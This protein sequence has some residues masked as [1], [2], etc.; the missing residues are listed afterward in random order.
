MVLV[1][2][3]S[4]GMWRRNGYALANQI[5]FYQQPRCRE[6]ML[7]KDIVMMQACAAVMPADSFLIALLNK[8]GLVSWADETFDATPGSLF[9]SIITWPKQCLSL[10]EVDLFLHNF[11]QFFVLKK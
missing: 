11:S 6:E 1:A 10:C 5:F 3:A 4:A 2:Q 9:I 7:D 8:F